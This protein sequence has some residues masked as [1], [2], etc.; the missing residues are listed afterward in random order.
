MIG[1]NRHF[2]KTNDNEDGPDDEDAI[3]LMASYYKSA[4]LPIGN[5]TNNGADQ[6]HEKP[7]K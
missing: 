6:D 1:P 3:Q 2:S 7:D 4:F 5:S